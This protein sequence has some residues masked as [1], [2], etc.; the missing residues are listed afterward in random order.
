MDL[1]IAYNK[2]EKYHLTKFEIFKVINRN[3]IK[4]KDKI[5]IIYYYQ[6]QYVK[7]LVISLLNEKLQAKKNV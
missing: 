3:K 4:Q 2:K 6:T 5:K 1:I 7:I